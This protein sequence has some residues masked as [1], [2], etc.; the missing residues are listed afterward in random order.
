M[1][2]DEYSDRGLKIHFKELQLEV[3]NDFCVD[4]EKMKNLSTEKN[5]RIFKISVMN[6]YKDFPEDDFIVEG[7]EINRKE[8]FI[9]IKTLIEIRKEHKKNIEN[10]INELEKMD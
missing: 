10:E 2:D 9:L 7:I 4:A 1:Y 3:A 8:F 5:A 6:R